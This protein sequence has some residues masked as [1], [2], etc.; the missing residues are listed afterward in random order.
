M[1][2][3]VVV[4]LYFAKESTSSLFIKFPSESLLHMS[5]DRY[6]GWKTTQLICRSFQLQAGISSSRSLMSCHNHCSPTL[7]TAGFLLLL[8]E[9]NQNLRAASGL[10]LSLELRL[11]T[12]M[13]FLRLI[14]RRKRRMGWARWGGRAGGGTAISS[15]RCRIKS[16]LNLEYTTG[17]DWKHL[18]QFPLIP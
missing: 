12:D 3:Y 10:T 15:E 18:H 17:S 14:Q 7:S 16:S 13:T 9:A 8:D 1:W 5:M 6:G 4:T 11:N 2:T